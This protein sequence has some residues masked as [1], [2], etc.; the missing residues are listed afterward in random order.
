MISL[1]VP[2]VRKKIKFPSKT[3]DDDAGKVLSFGGLNG[4][5]IRKHT[6]K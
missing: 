1:L 6:P 5:A 4:I 2:Y 3:L